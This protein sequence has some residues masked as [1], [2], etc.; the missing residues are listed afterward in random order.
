MLCLTRYSVVF[1]L[2]CDD[3]NIKVNKFLNIVHMCRSTSFVSHQAISDIHHIFLPLL[4]LGP[5]PA[6]HS[7]AQRSPAQPSPAQPSPAQ[8][9]L[10]QSSSVQSTARLGS[11]G[12]SARLSTAHPVAQLAPIAHLQVELTL[13]TPVVL[14]PCLYW[15]LYPGTAC[16]CFT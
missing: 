9:S 10:V 13:H 14:S 8:P 12:L 2:P 5:S 4:L 11:A 16:R 6:R 7:P 3:A 15:S 1:S